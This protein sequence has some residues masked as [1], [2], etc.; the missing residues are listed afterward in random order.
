MPEGG[1]GWAALGRGV[2][3]G[4]RGGG[5]TRALRLSW[6]Y[7]QDRTD[8]CPDLSGTWQP[9]CAAGAAPAHGL[10]FY[11]PSSSS[12]G[13]VGTVAGAHLV[14][15]S[16]PSPVFHGGRPWPPPPPSWSNLAP[17]RCT[18]EETEALQGPGTCLCSQTVPAR[19][20][21]CPLLGAED[22][23][24]EQRT[25]RLTLGQPWERGTP[26]RPGCG[27]QSP[28]I[29]KGC[30]VT[31]AGPVSQQLLRR[32]RPG[33][34]RV[35]TSG[36]PG[37]TGFG[38]AGQGPPW[39]PSGYGSDDPGEGHFGQSWGLGLCP[40]VTWGQGSGVRGVSKA[41]PAPLGVGAGG[42]AGP[43]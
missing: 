22:R 43:R 33:G 1:P 3:W 37:C 13:P 42:W 11:W 34:V 30:R 4:V 16:F 9:G 19:P 40:W 18:D 31:A 25:A 6:T 12:L 24:P 10:L 2:L 23:A 17:A 20:Q 14:W 26:L 36:W 38:A 29:Q 8:L 21:P 27:L 28:W 39:M 35:G 5:P 7:F 41:F 32:G 15:F